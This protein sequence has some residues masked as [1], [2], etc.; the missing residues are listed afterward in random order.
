MNSLLR[1]LDNLLNKVTMYR[2]MLYY[3]V[4]LFAATVILSFLQLLPY[5]PTDIILCGSYIV[6]VSYFSNQIFAKLFNVRPNLESQYITG[7]I[8]ALIVGPLALGQNILFLT[9]LPII[10]M[11][12]KYIIVF[13]KQHIFNPAAFAVTISAIVLNQGA[14]WWAGGSEMLILVIAGG[15]IMLRKL[16]R[17]HLV[18]SFLISYA[19]ILTVLNFNLIGVSGIPSLIKGAYLSPSLVFFTFIMLTE[20]ITSP[21]N[22]RYRIYYGIFAGLFY[23]LVSTYLNIF[24]T[25]ELSLLAANLVFRILSFSEKYSLVLQEKKEISHTIWEFI[26]EPTKKFAF[27]PGQY[28]EWSLP[29]SHTDSRGNRRYFTIASSPSE[30]DVKLAVKIPEK[31]SSF[32]T[33]LLSLKQGSEIYATN[34]EGEFVLSQDTNTKY[35]FVAGGIGITPFRSIIKYMLDKNLK[36]PITLF[37]IA[38]DPS[39]FAYKDL[40]KDAEKLGVKTVYVVSENVLGWK[41][42][43][44]RLNEDLIKKYAPEFISSLFYLSGPQPMVMA[45][46][47][48]LQKVGRGKIKYKVDFFPGYEE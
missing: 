28:L 31:A 46:E 36:H 3:L 12:S 19:V 39:E 5:N 10:A 23:A 29:H 42:E 13:K 30:K 40:F 15:L 33:K 25:L 34:L 37:Y 44:G 2:L 20:P 32:K 22:R 4:I 26:F 17:F 38:K 43:T 7:F 45:Y 35:V 24:Y 6:F 9:L 16:R 8:L 18:I 27:V 48:L 1:P 14:S 21:A 11:A 41:G 47:D